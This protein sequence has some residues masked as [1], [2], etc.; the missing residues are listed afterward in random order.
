MTQTAQDRKVKRLEAQV[1][2]LKEE[3]D[4]LKSAIRRKESFLFH[5]RDWRMRF[6]ALVKEAVQEDNLKEDSQNEY[7]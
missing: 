5:E 4:Q 2:K 1:K 7:W 3:V 6:Q